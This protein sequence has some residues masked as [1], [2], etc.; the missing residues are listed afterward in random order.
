MLVEKTQQEFIKNGFISTSKF[1]IFNFKAKATRALWVTVLSGWLAKGIQ[2]LIAKINYY[3]YFITY[4]NWFHCFYWNNSSLKNRM[5]LQRIPA[6]SSVFSCGNQK[7][8]Q[9]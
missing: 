8:Q 5:L 7:Q 2:V 6:A 3:N 4:A 1:M 9:E